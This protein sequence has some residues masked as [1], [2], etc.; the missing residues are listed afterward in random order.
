M[1]HAARDV[2]G[3]A[4]CGSDVIGDAQCG[5]DAIGNRAWLGTSSATR[6][7]AARRGMGCQ[8][9]CARCPDVIANDVPRG[10]ECRRRRVMR[11]GRRCQRGAARRSL[12]RLGDPRWLG[13]S[14]RT[15]RRAGGDLVGDKA[16][17]G[18]GSSATKRGG[19]KDVVGDDATRGQPATNAR[20]LR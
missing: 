17:C 12:G 15:M 13:T 11:L 1:R 5:S 9:E 4:Q 7:G 6:R 10:S 16:R 3:D 2:I 20:S 19:A 18:L 14:S 8:R